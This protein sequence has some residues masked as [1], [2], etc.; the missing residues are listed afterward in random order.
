MIML[1]RWTHSGQLGDMMYGDLLILVLTLPLSLIGK[2]IGIP[3]AEL[4]AAQESSMAEPWGFLLMVGPGVIQALWMAWLMR[5]TSHRRPTRLGVSMAVTGA[6]LMIY[7]GRTI[8]NSGWPPRQPYGAPLLACGIMQLV[9]LAALLFIGHRAR[10]NPCGELRP[11]PDRRPPPGG[12]RH[13]D[14]QATGDRAAGPVHR[15]G[16]GAAAAQPDADHR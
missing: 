4:L 14:G 9:A 12:G 16:G 5:T 3:A 8:A 6:A 11:R 13:R 1:A 10:S 15:R 7:F 2:A